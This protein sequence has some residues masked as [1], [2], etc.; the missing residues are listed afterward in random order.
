MK[1]KEFRVLRHFRRESQVKRTPAPSATL[2]TVH[3]EFPLVCAGFHYAPL[4]LQHGDI[5]DETEFAQF[6]QF[7]QTTLRE[8][9]PDRTVHGGIAPFAQPFAGFARSHQ[10]LGIVAE[11][12][13]AQFP[14][15]DLMDGACHRSQRSIAAVF[16]PPGERNPEAESQGTGRAVANPID[17]DVT[18][19]QCVQFPGL[20]R[21]G[22]AEMPGWNLLRSMRKRSTRTRK[23]NIMTAGRR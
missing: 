15:E 18:R 12:E 3:R 20:V 2:R 16:P 1:E 19:S 22:S 23:I 4:L 7:A 13:F 9:P 6:P 8:L 5:I 21:T 10:A 11:V 17:P 14:L